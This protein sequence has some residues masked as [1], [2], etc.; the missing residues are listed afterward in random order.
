MNRNYYN[1]DG[2]QFLQISKNGHG[3]ASEEDKGIFGE[4]AHDYFL[5]ETGKLHRKDARELTEA[6]RTENGD[7]L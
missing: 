6:E 4:H 5:D 2:N 1:A 3:N 7:V